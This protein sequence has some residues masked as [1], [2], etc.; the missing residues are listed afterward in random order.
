MTPVLSYSL[1]SLGV[2]HCLLI[3]F[4]SLL[5][6]IAEL[7][8]IKYIENLPILRILNLRRNPIQVR[9]IISISQEGKETRTIL[10]YF[11]FKKYF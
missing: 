8:E 2:V 10:E 3:V 1:L 7:D 5:K 4:F 9:V 11:F 6:Q